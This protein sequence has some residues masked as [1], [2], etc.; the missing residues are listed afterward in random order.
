MRDAFASELF[1][2]AK[3][4]KNVMF[5]TA[6]LGFGV[7][8]KFANAMPNQYINVGV[9]EQNMIGIATG[10]GLEGKRVFVYSIGNF[11]S[12]RCLE[13]IRNDAA[14]HEINLT[15][16]C[17]GGGFNY[18]PLGMSHHTT[19]DIAVMRAIPNITVVA[20]ST[21]WEA[22]QATQNLGKCKGVSYLRIEKGGDNN[23][24]FRNSKFELGKHIVHRYGT[25]VC[26]ITAGSII[27]ECFDAAD[28]LE[29]IG[30]SCKIISMHTIKPIDERAIQKIARNFKNI[31]TVEEHNFHGGLGSAV[32]EVLVKSKFS[33]NFD[34][35]AV[36]NEFSSIVGNQKY[37]RKKYKIDSNS[38]IKAIKKIIL[39]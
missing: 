16:V 29:K 27:N 33:R 14:Y 8:D 5:I 21:A 30:I 6:D 24:P 31:I 32:A 9:A 4:N 38:I 13:Q 3:S 12:F 7:F 23:P 26:I 11:V 2:L 25:D 36:N 34:S 20:P 28:K 19:E 22:K 15:I 17:S 39:K 1:K 37:L 35:V 18:G 10:L